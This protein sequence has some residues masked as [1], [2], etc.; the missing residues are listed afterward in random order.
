MSAAEDFFSGMM[1]L[2]NVVVAGAWIRPEPE[3]P[4][5]LAWAEDDVS[6][7]IAPEYFQEEHGSLTISHYAD[8]AIRKENIHSGVI[9]EQRP[10]GSLTVSLPDGKIFRQPFDG[11]PLQVLDLENPG[12]PLSGRVVNACIE[13]APSLVYH[14]ED[15][16]AGHYVVEVSTLR[17][18]Q[19]VDTKFF[20]A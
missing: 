9:Q 5:E 4:Q 19:V 15:P 6:L 20:A 7:D 8:G 16:Q 14:Y 1:S 2:M 13:D 17:Y 3:L 10:D 11:A 18:F 12:A